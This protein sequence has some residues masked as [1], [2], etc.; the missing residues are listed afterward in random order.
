M[1]ARVH[2]LH[3]EVTLAHVAEGAHEL[4]YGESFLLARI[5][6]EEA[7][8]KL[9]FAVLDETHELPPRPV[10]DVGVDHRPF[11]L[12]RP[13]RLNRL[14]RAELRAVLVA[15]RQMQ[16]E[17]LI[18]RDAEPR[19]FVGQRVARLLF[20]RLLCSRHPQKHPPVQ[21][22]GRKAGDGVPATYSSASTASTSIRAPRGRA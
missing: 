9:G 15:Q 8:N 4:A 6:V 16:H 11:Y 20:S 10:L 17:I 3:S 14:Q 21:R 2:H 19:E 13:A 18:A 12:P 1:K 22:E 5:E 7:Q